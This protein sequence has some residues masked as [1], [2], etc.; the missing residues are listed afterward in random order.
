M[1]S[2]LNIITLLVLLFAFQNLTLAQLSEGFEGAFPP[3]SWA[4]YD[5]GVKQDL[6]WE[7]SS[8]NPNS[9]SLHALIRSTTAAGFAEDWLVTPQLL[10][11]NSNNTLMFSAADENVNQGGIFS[12]RVSTDSQTDRTDFVEVATYSGIDFTASYQQFTVDLSAYEDEEIYI[13]FVMEN[14]SGDEVYL[15][16]ISGPPTATITA[17]PNCDQNLLQPASDAL[18][19]VPVDATLEW[20]VPSGAATSYSIQIGTSQGATD[21]LALTNVGT[22]TSYD[23]TTDFAFNTRYYVTVFPA[24]TNGTAANCPE[25]EFVTEMDPDITVDCS[26]FNPSVDQTLCYENDKVESF[27]ID[28]SD[29]SEVNLLFNVGTVENNQDEVYIYDGTDNSGRLLNEGKLYGN[30]GDLT[31]LSYT[32][33]TGSLFVELIPDGSNDCASGDQTEIDFS[34][35]CVDCSPPIGTATVGS[36]DGVNSQFSISVDITDLGDGTVIISND[37]NANTQTVTTTGATLVGP[38]AFGEVTLSLENSTD[39]QCNVELSPIEVVACPPSNDDCAFATALVPSTDQTCSTTNSGTTL[40][41]TSSTEDGICFAD[42]FDVWHAFTPLSSGNYIFELDNL[43]AQSIGIYTGNCVTG[44]TLLNDECLNDGS[45]FVSL[46]A[47]VPYLVQVFTDNQLTAGP[48]QLCVYPAPNP[49]ANDLCANAT[50]LSNLNDQIL[51]GEDIT[52]ATSTGADNCNGDG[53]GRGVWYTITGNGDFLNISV[54]PDEWDAVIQVWSGSCG[55]LTCETQVDEKGFSGEEV[56][57]G[58]QTTNAVTYYI[59][60]GAAPGVATGVFDLEVRLCPID[61]TSVLVTNETCIGAAN[62]SLTINATC[63]GCPNNE[64]DLQYSVDGVN[65]Q[66]ESVFENLAAGTYTITIRQ[67]S[68]NNCDMVIEREVLAAATQCLLL[69]TKVFLQGAFNSTDEDMDAN[70]SGA[71]FLIP[72]TEPFTTQGYTFIGGGG[73]STTSTVLTNIDDVGGIV[74]WVVVELRDSGDQATVLESRAALLRKDGQI[75]SSDNGLSPLEFDLPTGNSYY[76]A[77]R[78]RNHLSILTANAIPFD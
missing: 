13:A 45:V 47:G 37:Q 64:D 19:D 14:L 33:T 22:G 28:G 21:F 74:D 75:V 60:V 34:A 39:A 73:E 67:I 8:D 72:T 38:F 59:Y 46:S 9:G 53:I 1:K 63:A 23:P 32:S 36:C 12:V 48:Y 17:V 26:D 31:G 58:V 11:D 3:A 10:P 7:Q 76:V 49:P 43:N 16:D 6:S 20:S 50:L 68:N 5:N 69:S 51:L 42:G 15:D 27:T 65:F 41:A 78:H 29:G 40:G 52:Y 56:V 70:L 25:F 54:D 2:N 66:S 71:P 61:I 24:N 30:G 18:D 4:V 57:T 44:L 62:G 35:S 77:V 55:S